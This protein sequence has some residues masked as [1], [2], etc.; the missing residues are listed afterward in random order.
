MTIRYTN[1]ANILPETKLRMYPTKVINIIGGPGCGKSM[2]SAAIVL[3]LHL[4][5][6]TVE[7]IPDHAKALVW[8]RNFEVLKNQYFIAQRQFEMLNLLDGQ[9]Q[10]LM[11]ESSLP[12]VLYYNESY[13]A[14]ICDVEKTRAQ[15]LEWHRMYDNVN[16]LVERGEKRYVRAGRFQEEE[17]ARAIDL[18]LRALLDREAIPYTVLAPDIDAIN[19]F[20]AGLLA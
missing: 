1:M 6:K 12:Q 3:Y 10:F 5:G 20:A 4:H 19:A 9:V 18:G 11:T 2:F 14:N 13:E 15:I 17:Q 8:Q 7:T 16:I